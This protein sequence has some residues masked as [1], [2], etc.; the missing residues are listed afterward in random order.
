MGLR[1][2]RPLMPH[3]HGVTTSACVVNG[4]C[5]LCFWAAPDAWA[6]EVALAVHE[7]EAVG[8]PERTTALPQQVAMVQFDSLFLRNTPYAS[9]DVSRFAKGPAQLPGRYELGVYVN[10]RWRQDLSVAL[11]PNQATGGLDL[12]LDQALLRA[13]PLSDRA[14][15]QAMAGLAGG[16]A[17]AP[18]F[19]GLEGM[20]LQFKPEAQRLDVSLPQALLAERPAGY[21]APEQWASGEVAAFVNYQANHH[22]R[23]TDGVRQRD[24]ALGIRAGISAYGWALRHSGYYA[25]AS[26]EEGHYRGDGVYLQT[27]VAAVRAQLKM[28]TFYTEGQWQDS[29]KLRGVQ[30]SSDERM[31]PPEWR[32]YAPV[33]RGVAR[34]NAKVTIR[35][36]DRVIYETSVPAGAF[37]IKDVYPLGYAGNLSVTVTEAD[38]QK[39]TF[40]VPFSSVVQLLRPGFSQYSVAVGQVAD[41]VGGGERLWQGAWQYGVAND[42]TVN[43]SWQQHEQYRLAQAGVAVNTAF[44]AVGLA[45][46]RSRSHY[47]LGQ[48]VNGQFWRMNYSKRLAGSQTSVYASATYYSRE[49]AHRLYDFLRQRQQGDEGLGHERYRPKQDWQLSVNQALAPKWGSLYV[50][51]SRAQSWGGQPAQTS[52]Q[53]GY[54]NDY[55]RLRYS[56]D[57]SRTHDAGT[58]AARRQLTLSLSLP[59]TKQPSPHTLRLSHLQDGG[60]QG[61][62]QLA[63]S[64][65]SGQR[66]QLNYGVSLSQRRADAT[67]YSGYATH[68]GS[69]GSLSLSASQASD[70]RQ[71]AIGMEGAVVAHS[72]GVLLTPSVGDSFVIIQAKGA[73]GAEINNQPGTYLNHFGQGV[74]PYVLPYELNYVAIDPKGIDYRVSLKQTEKRLVPRGSGVSVVRFA[75]QFGQ[76]ILL[77]LRQHNGLIV[78][79]GAAATDPQGDLIGFVGQGGRLYAQSLAPQGRL[80]LRWLAQGVQQRCVVTYAAL[81]VA[82]GKYDVPQQ[83]AS[84]VAEP[85]ENEDDAK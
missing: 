77:R 4:L 66:Q 80:W 42:V 1:H 57:L 38:G 73:A 24:E 84:C 26:D 60:Q 2:S 25:K 65:A 15:Q 45:H 51:G 63:Y 10:G 12:C 59:L 29:F 40:T 33:V 53:L 7:D 76:P 79:M 9:V 32:G 47:G 19:A 78:P 34:S 14:L 62:T 81:P 3:G 71:A 54:A 52:L 21:V 72:Q 49:G 67:V 22:E 31:L 58:G 48:T 16:P 55:R 11:A 44:G 46:G 70:N 37:S 17:C 6:Q 69:L 39:S 82:Q 35:Q 18:A 83:Q 5:V 30:L 74:V 68:Q 41:E 20:S 8:L 23:E 13:W 43:A 28:G 64:G 27:D 85:Q 36:Q 75:T 56:L 50:S 61:E